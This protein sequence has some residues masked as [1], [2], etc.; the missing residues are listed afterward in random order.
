MKAAVYTRVSSQRQA[1]EGYSLAQQRAAC[2]QFV[3]VKGW[4][5]LGTFEDA[6]VS[7][8]RKSRPKLDELVGLIEAGE[9]DVLVSP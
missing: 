2:E 5:L 8:G 1:D 6:G 3:E 7:G 9:V 4:T